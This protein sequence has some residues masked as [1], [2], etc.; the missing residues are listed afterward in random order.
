[1]PLGDVNVMVQFNFK[2]LSIS[3]QSNRITLVVMI[4]VIVV[5]IIDVSLA[6]VY[7][8]IAKQPTSNWRFA[9]FVII[10]SIC[11]FANYF[12]LRYVEHNSSSIRGVAKLHIGKIHQVARLS[13]LVIVGILAI[14]VLQTIVNLRYNTL[15]VILLVWISYGFNIAML[16]LLAQRFFSWAIS[17]KDPKIILYAIA[18]ATL[19]ISGGF[20]LVF[21]NNVLVDRPEEMMAYS[22]GSM[23]SIPPNS[24]RSFLNSGLFV[25]AI[26]SFV[27]LWCATAVLLRHHVVK[28]GAIKYWMIVA[29]PLV[30]FLG[31]FA[32]F[33]AGLFDQFLASDPVSFSIWITLIFT[34]SKPAGGILFGIAF[35]LIARNFRQDVVLR[36]YLVISAFGFVLLFVSDHASALLVAPFPPFGVPSVSFVGLASYLI[37]LGIYSSVITI[38]GDVK[39]SQLI[40]EATLDQSKFLSSMA[41]ARVKQ[42]TEKKVI[43]IIREVSDKTIEATGI[44]SLPS[45]DDLRQSILMA[46]K[47]SKGGPMKEPQPSED[48][49]KQYLNEV[50]KVI[51]SYKESSKQTDSSNSANE[52]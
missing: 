16:G 1:M 34:L 3:S 18:S 46:F 35:Y 13:Q 30:L 33:L 44:T 25:S 15:L 8:L 41:S 6:R 27:S 39:L 51:Q 36:N 10:T 9:T 42:E 47:P 48:D 45:E 12:V 29:S 22:G 50:L 37:L 20:S 7:D 4:I 43:K 14:L 21:V 32:S 11:I 24:E 49:L 40:R 2:G 26:I 19:S 23:V 5:M 28:L 52:K 17:N 31:Q 38:S